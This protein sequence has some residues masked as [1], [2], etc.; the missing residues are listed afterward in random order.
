MN[1]VGSFATDTNQKDQ[2]STFTCNTHTLK[3]LLLNKYTWILDSR[4]TNHVC[5][6]LSDFSTYHCINSISIKLHN[7]HYVTAN[8]SGIVNLNYR[9]SLTNV[10]YVPA[11]SFNLISISKLTSCLQ[12]DLI[13][14]SN[15]FIIQDI[16]TKDKI[17]S[18]DFD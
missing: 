7:G 12:C 18:T 9:I 16:R 8:Y 13:F 10:L 2:D 11:F 5:C 4:A 1:Q 14:C 15:K 17:G 6:T 3:N